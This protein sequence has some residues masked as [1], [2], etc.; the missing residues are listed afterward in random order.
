MQFDPT[1]YLTAALFYGLQTHD[2]LLH[3]HPCAAYAGLAAVHLVMALHK[4]LLHS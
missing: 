2:A 3:R 4:L 1:L